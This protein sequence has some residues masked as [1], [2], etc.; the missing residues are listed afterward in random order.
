LPAT[1]NAL[2]VAYGNGQP[3]AVGLGGI[4][5]TSTDGVSWVQ[6]Q[7]GTT[8]YLVSI[9]YETVVCR[10]G[11]Q[12]TIQTS[13]DGATWIQQQFLIQDELRGIAYGNSQFVAVGSA[14]SILTSADGVN[15]VHRQSGTSNG[16]WA[17][18]YGNGHFVAVGE[19][20]TILQSGSIVTLELTPNPGTGLLTLAVR[21]GRAWLYD[22]VVQRSGPWQPLLTLPPVHPRRF[23]ALPAASDICFSA[24]ILVNGEQPV[25][26]AICIF[27]TL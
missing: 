12:V 4:V 27:K 2:S 22:P 21:P 26:Q 9:A 20:G 8:D 23:R 3:V 5:A 6:P 19:K 18:T 25:R 14:G 16:L 17:I 15:W 24:P 11:T 1:Q 10:C 13:A 7:S